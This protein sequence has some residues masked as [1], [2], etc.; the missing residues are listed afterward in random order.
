[1]IETAITNKLDNINNANLKKTSMN[2]LN[3]S[4]KKNIEMALKIKKKQK[5]KEKEKL[6]QILEKKEYFEAT[7]VIDTMM[8][9]YKP[10]NLII[11]QRTL[12]KEN[13]IKKY[14]VS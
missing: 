13:K 12:N 9:T 10:K 6:N 3:N 11:K 2:A 8:N 1:M 14:Q 4:Q 5:E 7:E